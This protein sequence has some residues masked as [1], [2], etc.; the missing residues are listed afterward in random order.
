MKTLKKQ[1]KLLHI[2]I[3][4]D[5]LLYG[6]YQLLYL[7]LQCIDIDLSVESP[8]ETLFKQCLEIIEE[9][10]RFDSINPL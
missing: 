3:A 6:K 7:V 5:L 10:K 2:Q 4:A 9:Q 1:L 8:V